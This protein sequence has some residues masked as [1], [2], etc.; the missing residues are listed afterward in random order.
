MTSFR[1]FLYLTA[2]IRDTLICDW[3]RIRR[4]QSAA[5][6][7]ETSLGALHELESAK[8]E[9][10]FHKH[11]RLIVMTLICEHNKCHECVPVPVVNLCH[12][13]RNIL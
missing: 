8:R 4:P 11:M 7:A 2:R 9:P 13:H 5:I 12:A 1:I 6:A 10:F 3:I